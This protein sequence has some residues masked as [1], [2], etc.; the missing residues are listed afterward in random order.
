MIV[1]IIIINRCARIKLIADLKRNLDERKQ[2]LCF[3]TIFTASNVS[4]QL[5]YQV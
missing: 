1:I 3:E 2:Q 5:L 4:W